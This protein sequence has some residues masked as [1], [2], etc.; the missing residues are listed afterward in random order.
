MKIIASTSPV[1]EQTQ[2]YIKISILAA[3]AC[4]SLKLIAWYFSGSVGLFSDALESG[5]NL[6]SAL[7]AFVILR[8]AYEPPDEM[9]PFGHSKA[10]Y[11]SSAFE[12]S[13]IFIAA[14]LII[15]AAI[16]RLFNPK[17][18]ESLGIGLWFSVGATLINF[19]VAIILSRAGKRLNSIVLTADS[20]HLMTDVWTTAG[21]IMGLFAVMLT[22]WL[23][24]DAVIAIAVALHILFEGYALLHDSVN[25]LMDEALPAQDIEKIEG[26]L[27]SHESQGIHYANLKTRQSASKRFVVVDILM[28]DLWD[29]SHAHKLL[30]EIEQSISESLG[31]ASVT[32]HLEPL[33]LYQPGNKQPSSS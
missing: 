6:A 20:R 27:K 1:A 23:W 25:G 2:A 3:C 29:I 4:I 33:S 18:L 31:G 9:H 14:V 8:K 16:P 22:N 17:P 10:E 19:A 21:V 7:F 5:V 24:L 13:M 32:T 11:F 28:P 15:Y 26:I 30:D 12:G